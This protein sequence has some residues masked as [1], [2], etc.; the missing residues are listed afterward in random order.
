MCVLL[1]DSGLKVLAVGEISITNCGGDFSG[2]PCIIWSWLFC[3]G[4][5]QWTTIRVSWRRL[6]TGRNLQRRWRPAA[7]LLWYQRPCKDWHPRFLLE[8]YCSLSD[9]VQV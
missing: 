7:M 1:K 3:C 6:R 5:I 4:R 9:L 8:R 2:T